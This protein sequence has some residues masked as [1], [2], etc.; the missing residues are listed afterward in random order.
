MGFYEKI[1]QVLAA[2]LAENLTLKPR[3]LIHFNPLLRADTIGF[4]DESP[5]IF[6]ARVP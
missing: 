4:S 3:F 6:V 2:M 1:T 5:S